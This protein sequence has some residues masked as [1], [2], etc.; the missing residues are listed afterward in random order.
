VLERRDFRAR[1]GGHLGVV[2]GNELARLRELVLD[3][4][5]PVGGA[6]DLG[7]PLVLTP[8]RGQLPGVAQRLR[9]EQLAFDLRRT[10]DGVRES[11]AEAQAFVPYFCRK[12]SMRPAVS[13]SFCL[14]VKNGWQFE[15]M[16]VWISATVERVWNVLPQAHFTVAVAYSG[17]MSVF[18]ACLTQSRLE[19]SFVI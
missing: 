18:M 8:Q 10:G 11:V 19:S 2:N 3:L 1:L 13:I 7:Q 16:S 4:P 9:V 14:P 15:Q 6:N 5:E 17:W 12:R